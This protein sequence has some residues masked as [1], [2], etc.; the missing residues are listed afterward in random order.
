[1]LRSCLVIAALFTPALSGQPAPTK[2]APAQKTALGPALLATLESHA[3]LTYARYGPREL[4]LDLHRPAARG[5]PLPAVV[6]LHGGGWFRG[7]RGNLTQL[8]QA[9]AAR[10][11]VVVTIS[12]RLSGEA[13]F[14][15]A[16]HDAKAAVRWLRA[17]AATYGI[18]PGAI[19]VTGLS[20]GGHL[21][22]LL[23]TSGGVAAL[24]GAGGHA[25]HSS[26]VQAAVAM[27]AQSDFET[28][29]IRTLSERPDDPHYTPFL[30]ATQRAQPA[31]YTLASPRHHV[32]RADPPLAFITG[33]LDDPST[34]AD[35]TRRDL[36]RLGV[37]TGLTVIPQAPHAF[38][39]Q[40]RAFDVAVNAAAAFFTLHL[41][42]RGRPPVE[43][44][45]AESPFAFGARWTTIG[46]GYGGSEGAQWIGEKLHFAA[47]HDRFAFT[48]TERAGLAVWRDDSPEA[49]SF[50]PDGRG[51]FYVVEQTT[52][53]LARWNARGER[54]E[55]LADRFEGKR[56]NRPNDCVVHADGTV[57]F[58]DPD[59]LFAQRK[60]EVKELTEQNLYRY[61][62]RTRALTAAARGFGKPNGL[63]FSPDGKFL[64][65]TDSAGADLLRFAVAADGSLGPREIF[66]TLK[67]RGLDGL[68]FDHA[69]RLWC[70]ALDGVHVF[71]A[72]GHDLGV[73]TLPSKATAIAFAAAPSRL[74]CITTREAA[75]VTNLR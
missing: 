14:P 70:A 25:A 63:A 69:G 12:Y 34:R 5:T 41:T 75:F 22:A 59:F 24:E 42:H 57:W 1:M 21:A 31:L 11:F 53:Q 37:A 33:E 49:T 74:V 50:R 7:E 68:A 28:D 40:Q 2:K 18:D 15:A 23:A 35:T 44:T 38:L 36:M 16:L 58:T 72:A 67:V 39:G 19:G 55:V 71:D 10:G 52:R 62:P 56:L 6:C 46:G 9:L 8:A 65:V 17:N 20:A 4:Q 29:R 32:D 64:F 47:H 13:K 45:L 73:I 66:A 51:S 48:W 3:G 61:D 26:A 27:G 30:G 43:T 54:I 60:D